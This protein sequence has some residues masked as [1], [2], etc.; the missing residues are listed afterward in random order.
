M[1]VGLIKDACFTCLSISLSIPNGVFTYAFTIIAIYNSY[2]FALS[3]NWLIHT[4]VQSTLHG[5]IIANQL[6]T[7]WY[8]WLFV[9]VFGYIFSIDNQDI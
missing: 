6:S 2:L 1:L 7:L 8:D 4:S 5:I 9:C 3:Q